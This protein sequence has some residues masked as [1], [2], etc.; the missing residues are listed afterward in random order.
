MAENFRPLGFLKTAALLAALFSLAA[1]AC[2][3]SRAQRWQ[4]E[5]KIPNSK[6]DRDMYLDRANC[7]ALAGQ[8][9]GALPGSRYASKISIQLGNI[10][11]RDCMFGKGYTLKGESHKF[12]ERTEG[13]WEGQRWNKWEHADKEKAGLA[14]KEHFAC[15]RSIA[16]QWP[17]WGQHYREAYEKCMMEK[18]FTQSFSEKNE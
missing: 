1:C 4:D 6:T 17:S 16:T 2:G 10:T 8:A 13:F 14:E 12:E 5:W 18:G 15:M 9:E 3:P 7:N 11:A